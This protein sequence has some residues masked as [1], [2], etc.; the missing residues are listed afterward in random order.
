[1]GPF[2]APREIADRSKIVSQLPAAIYPLRAYDN[3]VLCK[4]EGAHG[5][6]QWPRKFGCRKNLYFDGKLQENP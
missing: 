6:L 3:C 4:G 1:M 2:S 5:H